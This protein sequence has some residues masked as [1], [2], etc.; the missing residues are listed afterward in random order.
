VRS[1]LRSRHDVPGAL[2]SL[3]DGRF[4]ITGPGHVALGGRRDLA[5][6]CERRAA[7]PGIDG[8]ERAWWQ[9]VA[10]ALSQRV[11]R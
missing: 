7:R 5:R 4:A 8:A 2:V 1:R 11:V 3:A 6:W 10:G 9:E